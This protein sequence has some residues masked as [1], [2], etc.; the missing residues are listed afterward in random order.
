MKTEQRKRRKRE[1]E[2]Q[3]KRLAR[4]EEAENRKKN[5]KYFD[6]EHLP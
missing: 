1:R 3:K 4:G 5:W 2:K 6:L